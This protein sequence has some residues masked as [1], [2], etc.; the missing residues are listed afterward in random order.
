[1]NRAEIAGRVAGRVGL[2]QSAAGEAVD[3]VFQ[4]LAEALA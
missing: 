4:T 2:S 1:M 3:A